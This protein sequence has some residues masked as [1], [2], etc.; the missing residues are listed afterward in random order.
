[1]IG[2]KLKSLRKNKNITQDE[3]SRFL[4]V[5][6]QAVSKWERNLSTP[7]ISALPVIAGYFGITIDELLS[8]KPDSLTY[9]ERFIRFMSDN[10]ALKFGSYTLSSGRVSP[11]EIH[12][13][14]F[15][16]GS[17]L[18]KIGEFYAE[19]I[20]D[21][22]VRTNFL[23][24]NT[25]KESH[26][27]TAAAMAMFQKYGIDVKV[28]IEN[29]SGSLPTAGDSV[30]IIKDTTASGKTLRWMIESLKDNYGIVPTDV[31]IAVDRCEKDETSPLTAKH[32]IEKDYG[33]RVHSIIDVDD[34]VHALKNK[35]IPGAD[36][37]PDIEEYREKYKGL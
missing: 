17:Q 6:P 5:S 23:Y 30:T 28:C 12:T 24:A 21:S 8:Y 2:D 10:G 9:K 19:C 29:R 36:F 11:Y 18:A 20:R 34:I 22:N 25:Y 13:E 1:M 15:S 35:I 14:K 16:D 31:V 33:V 7:D 4:S 3:L 27:V 26:I 37:L 32:R